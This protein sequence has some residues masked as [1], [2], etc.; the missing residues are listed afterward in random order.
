[1]SLKIASVRKSKLRR[2][3]C[4]GLIALA[5]WALW[6]FACA[7]GPMKVTIT[8]L[9][10]TTNTSVTFTTREGTFPV[11][12]GNFRVSNL[13]S[14]RVVQWGV[15]RYEARGDSQ[16][17]GTGFYTGAP[18]LLGVLAPGQ[19]KTVSVMTP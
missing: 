14:G 17:A 13:G 18:E 12:A 11:T 6:L 1:M 19:S 7:A 9:G 3:L 5:C 15:C 10:T 4:A 8:Y 2:I 16:P